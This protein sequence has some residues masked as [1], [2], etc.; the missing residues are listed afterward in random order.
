MKQ[1]R[2]D[3]DRQAQYLKEGLVR[4]D[5][6]DDTLSASRRDG[7]LQPDGAR[8]ARMVEPGGSLREDLAMDPG[9][10]VVPMS[11]PAAAELLSS[12]LMHRP[13]LEVIGGTCKEFDLELSM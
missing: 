1:V 3:F 9:M 7:L 8:L 6:V 5:R 2:K 11:V 12:A 13:D 4:R 10:L